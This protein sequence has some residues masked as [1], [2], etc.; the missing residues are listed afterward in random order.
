MESWLLFW[1]IF[2]VVSGA[3]FAFITI[4]VTIKGFRNLLE[5]FSRLSEQ[6]KETRKH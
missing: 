6:Q 2:L 5:M 4:V 1:T 3:S